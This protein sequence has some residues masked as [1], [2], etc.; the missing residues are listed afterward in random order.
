MYPLRSEVKMKRFVILLLI[1]STLFPA[2]PASAATTDNLLQNPDFEADAYGVGCCSNVG[3]N[4]TTF[5]RLKQPNDPAIE[6]H[7]P[8]YGNN[9]NDRRRNGN[10]SMSWGKDY[11]KFEAG[12]FQKVNLPQATGKLILTAWAASW[13][14]NGNDWGG[15]PN[16]PIIKQIGIDPTGGTDVWAGTVVWSP[17]NASRVDFNQLTFTTDAKSGS[18][19]VFLKA[20]N[21][22]PHQRNAVFWDEIRLVMETTP[23]PPPG[24]PPA[25]NDQPQDERY[26]H[27]TGFRVSDDAFWDYFQKRGGVRTFGYPVSRKFRLLGS[28][29]Q[30]FQRRV[31]QK[32]PNG[33]VGLLNVLDQDFMPYNSF[34]NARI[35]ALDPAVV[36]QAPAPG[37]ANYGQAILDYVRRVAPNQWNGMNVNFL[38]TFNNAVT[39]QEV[40][41]S[42]PVQP[43]ILPGIDLELWGVPTS[44]PAPDPQNANFAYQRW[45]RGVMHY[46]RATGTT[47]GLLLA[48]YFKS[49]ITGWNL[50]PDVAEAAKASRFFQ[51]YNPAQ[52]RSLTRP[53]QLPDTDMTQAFIAGPTR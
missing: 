21:L 11:A 15:A 52:P 53:E 31:M 51:Q 32:Q 36:G 23:P 49:I 44:N 4:W 46:D 2:A 43:G 26:F 30:I 41:G 50:P 45:Q 29:V 8:Q 1:L 27:Q 22:Y 34:N 48:D 37:S 12:I 25:V 33:Q 20:R 39:A 7:E 19:T 40:F 35:P 14:G 47:Q 10:G 38:T 24:P 5:W 6:N 16:D 28:E 42:A 13:S 9:R 17:E 3:N 18:A